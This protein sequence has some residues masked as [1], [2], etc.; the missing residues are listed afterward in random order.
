MIMGSEKLSSRRKACPS[1]TVSPQILHGLLWDRKR[2]THSTY[3]L[4]TVNLLILQ[5]FHYF[6]AIPVLRQL[7]SSATFFKPLKH[8]TQ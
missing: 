8:C 2:F 5:F 4:Q 3:I 1:G 7:F 6:V